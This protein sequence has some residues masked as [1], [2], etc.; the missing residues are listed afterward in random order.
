MSEKDSTHFG[1]TQVDPQEKTRRV[2]EVFSS[3]ASRYDLMNDLMSFGVHRAWKRYAIHIAQIKP[4]A[5]ILDV[6]G[7]TGDMSVLFKKAAGDS[8]RVITSDINNAMLSEGRDRQLDRGVTTG[9][10]FVQAN[11][12]ALPFQ[13]NSFDCT[14]IAFGL[15]NVTDKDAAL[16]SMYENIKYG[17]SILILEFSRV[18]LPV[19]RELYEKYSFHFI[20]R[21]GELIAKD[22]ESY[23]YLVES[24]RMHPDQETL[25]AMLEDAGFSRVNY[26]NLSGG[27]VAIHKGYKL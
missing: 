1:F 14:C 11:A 2:G 22:R 16:R 9:L 23:Q 27:I 17:G 15:R 8:G 5:Q 20:P 7:G 19:L 26:H 10:E 13:K 3:V 4:G 21:L 24:I 25:K 12:E 18:V 6:A